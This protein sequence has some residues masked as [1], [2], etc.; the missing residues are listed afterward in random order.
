MSE[1]WW[2]A[3]DMRAVREEFGLTF[4]DVGLWHELMSRAMDDFRTDLKADRRAQLSLGDTNAKY[5][6]SEKL[7]ARFDDLNRL[8]L[9]MAVA[10]SVANSGGI[11]RVP[12][13]LDR[14]KAAGLLDYD[15]DYVY[16]N[17]EGQTTLDQA[18][19]AL[20]QDR[21]KPSKRRRAVRSTKEQSESRPQGTR[22]GTESAC[23]PGDLSR[24]RSK[25][26]PTGE[27]STS[28]SSGAA[29][30]LTGEPDARSAPE[31]SNTD[32]GAHPE[33]AHPRKRKRALIDLGNGT[34]I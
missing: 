34:V 30:A 31:S 1:Y 25:T 16:L 24:D 29:A 27:G 32:R 10:R 13:A 8:L 14:L 11:R 15:T 5:A 2:K 17:F 3:T 20:E 18:V 21:N 12:P 4:A 33:S 23:P 6:P 19:Q 26:S 22:V 9:P 7:R 28:Y